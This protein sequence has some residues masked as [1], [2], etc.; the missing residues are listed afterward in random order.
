MLD[1]GP[2]RGKALEAEFGSFL[3][4]AVVGSLDLGN[5]NRDLNIDVNPTALQMAGVL[6]AA[7][8]PDAGLAANST[9]SRAP[10]YT[11]LHS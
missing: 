9:S 7:I 6:T 3:S 10:K 5:A 4:P 1:S 11:G 2:L 8:R